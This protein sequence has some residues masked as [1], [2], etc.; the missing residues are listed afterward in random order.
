MNVLVTTGYHFVR[1]AEGRV[2]TDYESVAYAFWQRYLDVFEGVRVIARTHPCETAPEGWMPVT[3]PRVEVHPIPDFRSPLEMVRHRSHCRQTIMG[4]LDEAP[5]VILRIPCLI[6]GIASRAL[7]AA[8][9]PFAAEVLGD[10]YD[11]FSPGAFQSRFRPFYRWWFTRQL[12]EQCLEAMAASYVTERF[13]QQR[14]PT[15]EGVLSTNY[16]SIVLP[17]ESLRPRPREYSGASPP[18][19]L[20][21][22]GTLATLYKAPR[23]LL[24]A[25]ALCVRDGMQVELTLVGGGKHQPDLEQQAAGLGLDGHVRFLGQLPSSAAVRQELDRADLFVLPSFQEGLPRAMIEAMARALPA[26][27][28]TVGGIPELLPPEDMVPPGDAEMLARKIRE[29]AANPQR[30]AQMSA[31]NLEKARTY[32]EPTLRAR[33]NAYYEFVRDETARWMK[34]QTNSA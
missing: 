30:L 21:T 28:S 8:G 2:W 23:V 7:T 22:V 11:S 15:R 24:D 5:A 13:L 25:V 3:G 31:R 20:V 14:Y 16:S 9:H 33:R 10:P 17:T 4:T 18:V 32:D 6:G 29:V 12:R 1:D 27:G 26:I 34:Q 19:R